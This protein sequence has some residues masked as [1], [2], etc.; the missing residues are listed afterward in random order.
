LP[1]DDYFLPKTR[2]WYAKSV[3]IFFEIKLNIFKRKA[4]RLFLE[5]NGCTRF[6]GMG[7]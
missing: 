5:K 6:N 7:V 1:E 3:G 4:P 2:I